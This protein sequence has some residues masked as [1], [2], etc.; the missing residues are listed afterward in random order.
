MR[1]WCLF[2]YV[3]IPYTVSS[4]F[5]FIP[6]NPRPPTASASPSHELDPARDFVG[7]G[8]DLSRRRPGERCSKSITG[9]NDLHQYSYLLYS[10]HRIMQSIQLYL[11]IQWNSHSLLRL[12][13]RYCGTLVLWKMFWNQ[14]YEHCTHALTTIWTWICRWYLS[15]AWS[16]I[17]IYG[18]RT[19]PYCT[20]LETKKKGVCNAKPCP[21][22][23]HVWTFW[24]VVMENVLQVCLPRIMVSNPPVNFCK[25][26]SRHFAPF[27]SSGGKAQDLQAF[28]AA[29][30][31]GLCCDMIRKEGT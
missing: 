6:W 5:I 21:T 2:Q 13:F 11:Q 9:C 25:T 14:L 22:A 31:R 8:F 28:P 26:W 16:T 4:M 12:F 15:S 27:K 3:F 29:L 18:V 19:V 30:N 23:L 7:Q 1:G 24:S 20:W 10:H 17:L